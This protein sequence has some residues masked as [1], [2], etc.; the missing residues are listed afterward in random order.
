[1]CSGI[2]SMQLN[3]ILDL[4]TLDLQTNALRHSIHGIKSKLGLT[5]FGPIDSCI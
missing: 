2:Q 3:Q 4:H 5:N 1:M